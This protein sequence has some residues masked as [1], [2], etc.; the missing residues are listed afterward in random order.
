MACSACK[1][2]LP[3]GE[4]LLR[5]LSA[6]QCNILRLPCPQYSA[7]SPHRQAFRQLVQTFVKYSKMSVLF[8]CVSG[9][10]QSWTS[11]CHS[12]APFRAQN[13]HVEALLIE[14][15]VH[16]F[17]I[18]VTPQTCMCAA[19]TTSRVTWSCQSPPPTL[20][21]KH[22]FLVSH[23]AS[24]NHSAP[25]ASPTALPMAPL[26][27]CSHPKRTAVSTRIGCP[28]LTEAGQQGSLKG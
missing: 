12:V 27:I 18:G 11:Q 24:D 28:P 10:L 19:G 25:R 26:Y 15:I 16:V 2:Q 4:P 21:V 13:P 1:L 20:Q 8:V 22:S 14:I 6:H 5:A 23:R 7:P 3:S 17:C 9:A